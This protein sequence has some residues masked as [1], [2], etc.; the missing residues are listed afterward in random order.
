MLDPMAIASG[1]LLIGIA[2][3]SFY[4][5]PF[6]N[7]LFIRKLVNRFRLVDPG[8]F[9]LVYFTSQTCSVCETQQQPD[10]EKL[11]RLVGTGLQVFEIDTTEQPELASLCG[12]SRVPT[13]FLINPRGELRHVNHGVAKAEGLLIQMLVELER[14]IREKW[15]SGFHFTSDELMM[16]LPVSTNCHGFVTRLSLIRSR[17]AIIFFLSSRVR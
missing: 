1:I 17:G 13:T 9:I 16:D 11:S 4:Y 15:V 14:T 3:Y 2:I 10:L 6:W 7:H 5:S 8:T 12:V